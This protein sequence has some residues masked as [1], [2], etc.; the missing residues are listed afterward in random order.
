MTTK[1]H[2]PIPADPDGRTEVTSASI[3]KPVGQ[4]DAALGVIRKGT[5]PS[6][7]VIL[8]GTWDGGHLIMNGGHLW[9][10]DGHYWF[11]FG[12]FPTSGT[13]GTNLTER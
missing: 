5:D 3:N 10:H 8:E 6:G 2:D 13:D 7:N 1:F 9:A 12:R 4:L 11:R